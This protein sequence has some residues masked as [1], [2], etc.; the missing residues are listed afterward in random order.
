MSNQ[1]HH[2]TQPLPPRRH[3][4][5]RTIHRAWR[6]LSDPH[7][8]RGLPTLIACSG[9]PDSSALAIALATLPQR[10]RA[11]LA[12]AHA[13]HTLRPADQTLAD[14]N[15]TRDLA[16][17]LAIPF[18]PLD[19]P[20][21]PTEGDARAAR[22]TALATLARN[23]NTPCIATAHHANDQLETILLALARGAALNGL[24]GIAP[25]RPIDTIAP[26]ITL[27][28]PMLALDRADA[29]ELL[30]L[31]DHRPQHD[32]TNDLPTTP[33]NALRLTAIPALLEAL[34]IAATNT[35]SCA[36]SLAQAAKIIDGLAAPHIVGQ[37]PW[38]RPPLRTLEPLIITTALRRNLLDRT[39]GRAADKL[40]APILTTV[41]DAIRDNNTNPRP[42]P[43]PPPHPTLT[44]TAH[45]LSTQSD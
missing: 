37:G 11:K 39:K 23:L 30:T 36:A 20:S 32:P 9:G 38:P 8:Q 10:D 2:P 18:Y 27:I 1:P 7:H 25:S 15:A 5:V 41:A 13:R 35:L 44:L 6:T 29:A 3:P 22:Y 14:L 31:A 26:P 42:F 40:T 12:I 45:H 19:A 43:L 34:P 28:R 33:R 21:K 4:A 17:R 24:A 16:H